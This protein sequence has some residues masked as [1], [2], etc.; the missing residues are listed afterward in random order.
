MINGRLFNN[1]FRVTTQRWYR[2]QREHCGIWLSL[3]VDVLQ[4]LSELLTSSWLKHRGQTQKL[5]LQL[6]TVDVRY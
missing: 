6:R 4:R 2:K 1:T 5:A 3:V